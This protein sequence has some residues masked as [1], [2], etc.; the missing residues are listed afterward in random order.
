MTMTDHTRATSKIVVHPPVYEIPGTRLIVSATAATVPR[1][2]SKVCISQY[3]HRLLRYAKHGSQKANK[4]R[5]IKNLFPL[6]LPQLS[7]L[8]HPPPPHRQGPLPWHHQIF[9]DLFPRNL[10]CKTY[11]NRYF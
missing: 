1:Y 3:Y 6:S 11:I 2:L 4:A 5:L 9:R 8:L 10:L 7:P